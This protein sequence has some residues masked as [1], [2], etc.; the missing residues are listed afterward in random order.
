[1]RFLLRLILLGVVYVILCVSPTHGQDFW[2]AHEFYND[3]FSTFMTVEY[4]EDETRN[5]MFTQEDT[6]DSPYRYPRPGDP[7]LG[8]EC[9][10]DAGTVENCLGPVVSL[11]GQ[12]FTNIT[13]N[14]FPDPTLI[15]DI[16]IVDCPNFAKTSENVFQGMV[17]LE[18][19]LIQDTLL[20]IIPDLSDT[21]L[22]KLNLNHN[23][24]H[25]DTRNYTR[26]MM[27]ST[28]THISLTNNEII[29]LPSDFLAGTSV[30][31]A[32]F[33]NNKLKQFPQEAVRGLT[34]LV[35]L[36]VE[37]NEITSISKRNM[38]ALD[39][40]PMFQHLNL[41]NNLIRTIAAGAFNVLPN[42]QLLE[43]HQ[44]SLETLAWKVFYDLPELLYLDLNNNNLETLPANSLVNLPK[45]RELRL[46]SQKTPMT[47]I[48]F[49]AFNGI[50]SN[51]FMLWVSDNSLPNYPHQAL[52]EDIY[53][54][55][56][57]VH[58]EDNQIVNHTD[59][60]Q[61]AFSINLRA[62]WKA[63]LKTFVPFETT[64]N[65]QTLWLSSNRIEEIEEDDFCEM[66]ILTRLHLAGNLLTEDT[67][68]VTA[69]ACNLRLEFLDLSFNRIQYIPEAIRHSTGLPAIEELRLQSN[70]LTFL[71]RYA[72]SDLSTLK[73]LW[74]HN[75]GII[76]IEDGSFPEDNLNELSLYNNE[77]RF[78]HSN[79]F[80]NLGNLAE[81]L[82]SGNDIT[83]IPD[84]AFHGSPI[85]HLELQ[86]NKIGR[87]MKPHFRDCPMGTRLYLQNNDLAYI[88]DGSF[89]YFTSVLE[90]DLSNNKLT[91]L[92]VGGDFHDLN[93]DYLNIENN[94]I[95]RIKNGTFKNLATN[96]DIN[97]QTNR[98]SVIE[99]NAF[100]SVNSKK[101]TLQDNIIHHVYTES[102][103]DVNA[104][105]ILIDNSLLE[106]IPYCTFKN[107]VAKKLDLS[108]GKI[109]TIHD[110]AF[111]TVDVN[112]L[113]L[114][115]NLLSKIEGRLFSDAC[116]IGTLSLKSNLLKS[117][118]PETFLGLSVTTVLLEDN[119]IYVYP[120]QALSEINNIQQLS[121]ARN[122]LE[123]IPLFSFVTMINLRSLNIAENKLIEIKDDAFA[124]LSLL[125]DLILNNNQIQRIHDGAWNGLTNLKNLEI[126]N[127][128]VAY[129]PPFPEA[130][131]FESLDA[132]N[133]QIFAMADLLFNLTKSD[134]ISSVNLLNNPLGCSCNNYLS[135]LNVA[136]A[137]VGGECYFPLPR[138]VPALNYTFAKGSK[139][140]SHYFLNANVTTDDFQCPGYNVT[141]TALAEYELTVSWEQPADLI[142]PCYVNCPNGTNSSISPAML[143]YRVVCSSYVGPV[144]TFNLTSPTSVLIFSH[145]FGQAD[146]VV[147]GVDYS[148][149][150]QTDDAGYTSAKSAPSYITTI[151]VLSNLGG[152]NHPRD[153]ILEMFLT[154]FS[155]GHPDFTGLSEAVIDM[156]EYVDSPY[157]AWLSISNTPTADTFSDW[158]RDVSPSNHVYKEN[159]T[160][161]YVL[162][163]DPYKNRYF[164]FDFYPLDGRG[165]LAEGQ[166]DCSNI[167]HN[168]GF[169]SSIREGFIYQGDEVIVLAGGDE[170]W[171]YINKTLVL[172]LITDPNDV[173]IPCMSVDLTPAS[174]SGGGLIT[175]EIGLLSG[176]YDC[177]SLV[178]VTS[179][180]VWLELEVGE[181]FH[182]DMFHVERY[183][184]KSKIFIE[185]VG[186]VF[187]QNATEQPPLDYSMTVGEDFHINGIIGTVNLIDH[188]SFGPYTLDITR[189]NEGRHFTAVEDTPANQAL[190]VAPPV[191]PPTYTTLPGI[192]IS[193]VECSV[194]SVI[195]PDPDIPG[196]ESFSI[197]TST[198]LVT[199][200]TSLDYEYLDKYV[201][202]LKVTDQGTMLEGTICIRILLLDVN[203]NCPELS[204]TAFNIEAIPA[205]KPEP[206]LS[207]NVSDI[208]SGVNQDINF[209]ISDTISNPPLSGWND[210]FDLYE[211][212][213]NQTTDITVTIAAI[214]KG[215][216]P[217]GKT[218]TVTITLWNTCLID[219]LHRPV[220]HYPYVSNDTGEFYFSVPGY[221]VY[222][223]PCRDTIGIANAIIY[224]ELMDA[225]THH[226]LGYPGRGRLNMTFESY[227][228]LSGGWVADV[229]DTA[230]WIQADLMEPHII[231][232]IQL[233][234]REDE[235]EWV[236]QVRI[237][238]SNNTL[239]PFVT[240]TDDS[241]V[242]DFPG[243]S[244]RNTIVL[245]DLVPPLYGQIVRLNPRAWF[246]QIALRFEVV[247]C[248][249]QK[250]FYHDVN[251]Q[252]CVAGYY[253]EGD[254]LH[255]PCGWCDPD[256]NTTCNAIPSEHSYGE[257]SQCEP[258]PEGHIC[259][260]GL[261]EYCPE[262]HYIYC[263]NT[264][265]ATC[266]QC[267]T[268]Y[269]C[270]AGLKYACPNGTYSDGYQ[271]EC[272]MC[273]PGTYQ[274]LPL[275]DHCINCPTGFYS[276]AMKDQC[277]W[278]PEF[279]YSKPDGTGCVACD[280]SVCACMQDPYPCF[281]DDQSRVPCH[282][283]DG[284]GFT[285]DGC[286]GGYSGDGVTC[287]D[288]DE[289]FADKPCFWERCLNTVPGYQ[290]YECPEGYN[291]TYED[292]ITVIDTMRVF[293]YHNYE[294][295]GIQYQRCWDVDECLINN[296]RCDPH[297]T[298]FNAVGN[299]SCGPCHKGYLGNPYCTCYPDNFCETG[300]HTCDGNATCTYLG[301]AAYR[302]DCID[303]YSG[304]GYVC[305]IDF[306]L[307]GRPYR[308]IPCEDPECY[309]D[310][311]P[312]LP[313]SGQEDND[314][315]SAGDYCDDDDDNDG[316]PDW[317]D[318]C[319]LVFNLNQ[320]DTD[321]DGIGD[322]CDNC[323]SVNDT[324]Q[325]DTD[326]DGLGNPCDSDIDGDG[327]ANGADNCVYIAND[328]TNA[329][330]DLFGDA[331]DNCPI[332]SNNVQTD[333]NQN[334]YGDACDGTTNIDQDGDGVP[335][336]ADNCYFAVNP[337]QA[338]TDNDGI[339]D[340]CDDD[341]DGDGV[342]NEVDNCLYV[343]NSGQEDKN[344][345]GIGDVCTGDTDGDGVLDQY[346]AC[347]NN[348]YINTTDFFH[349]TYIDLDPTAVNSIDPRWEII[350]DG[351][352]IRQLEDAVEKP[353]ML[354]SK[355]SYETLDY[356][357][358]FYV[359]SDDK[360]NYIGFVFGYQN[361]QKFYV[362]M[363]QSNNTNKD[364]TA[365]RG[366]LRGLQIKVVTS[367][368]GPGKALGNALWHSADTPG[369]VK[370]IWHDPGMTG[371][372]H[373][374]PYRWHLYHRP[375]SGRIRFR[376]V[377]GN[378][379]VID[380]GNIY[381]TTIPGGRIGV[382]S[383]NQPQC[384]WSY[385]VAR[386]E[387]R[388]NE[389]LLLDGVDDYVELGTIAELGIVDSFTFETWL[390]LPDSY[391]S[392]KQPIICT[393]NS[394]LCVYIENGLLKGQ[395][396]TT[397]IE[398]ATTIQAEY[399]HHV[400]MRYDAQN[401]IL[402]LYINGT[403]L[404]APNP[405]A[406]Q[407]DISPVCW[408]IDELGL[409][410]HCDD[411]INND[412]TLYLGTENKTAFFQGK[413]D[414]VRL[415]N[416]YLQNTE[417]DGHMTSAGLWWQKH[418]QY[419]LVHL[420]MDE[421]D[422]DVI[423][424]DKGN[425]AHNCTMYGAPQ[426]VMSY[427]NRGRFENTY[428]NNRR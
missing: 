336:S 348:K 315:D 168:F 131:Q 270:N 234:G 229:S 256:S 33:A 368:T 179:Q 65:V 392:T 369:Q 111:C 400:T 403:S 286:P 180:S 135:L 120:A 14:T 22:T 121:L 262:F 388:I 275:Q 281:E 63:R 107:V 15:T 164:D 287:V 151:E 421:N 29:W 345:D 294:L 96:E 69:W 119:L 6:V 414:E 144:L 269:A 155:R 192:N 385:L 339:G 284:G 307:D 182:F 64:P 330:G 81:L 92:P 359:R 419:G 236:T 250:Q 292:G 198:S 380:S 297:S 195:T 80:S 337:S 9:D 326:L 254:G 329:D 362:V 397:I 167:V 4:T 58:A 227:K 21:I 79:P 374:T 248:P 70:K 110:Q 42:L 354:I 367:S 263:T 324:D 279:S 163:T 408:N 232:Q 382:F 208:D 389:A 310:N 190:G 166:R 316:K 128:Q 197:S 417:L 211:V 268:G 255:H 239:G 187:V 346:D 171:L 418:K 311:C 249:I 360:D 420:D 34:D 427:K 20:E 189:G 98:I 335:D 321:G 375:T 349:S 394:V 40:S 154:D 87:I 298:C 357:G 122:Q 260:Q 378:A 416:I 153:Y 386:C 295:D 290:C 126:Q 108:S 282:D 217:R 305:D 241:A 224:D 407:H 73:T 74:L 88:E 202:V 13:N 356:S 399:W 86:Y 117:I 141:T 16:T 213:Y 104:D 204:Q 27:P 228:L 327:T 205:L 188:F 291:G 66:T 91:S 51:L 395:Y 45:L 325:T 35:Y 207:I 59:Y 404:S 36:G 341:M 313:N 216:P 244:D 221:W 257:S 412:T 230:Q 390:M 105:N 162:G 106:E 134:S 186:M 317:A 55:L 387:D 138:I 83:V 25:F 320:A 57:Q 223:Y 253:C 140:E 133:N 422:D 8:C 185:T 169:T 17:Q 148:C 19:M 353:V 199:L 196:I 39:T 123:E 11:V 78:L 296:G 406:V 116:I 379:T 137:I 3:R 206:W 184:C 351:K 38:I 371:W 118:P 304:N 93:L 402:S 246:G 50:N 85:Q 384:V 361:N 352:E 178:P 89:D 355:A 220:P 242:T 347:R 170:M 308:N 82:L 125:T 94:R 1:M 156:P 77:F 411:V 10:I 391:S 426:F 47:S 172:Q 322:A 146:G 37:G 377:E 383:Y 95:T 183:W 423:L 174:N 274:D 222:N 398:G 261:A 18:T 331:C 53:P 114:N 259:H 372:V 90:M 68:H 31:F 41:S 113:L 158:F 425:A 12:T 413:V 245:I 150:V 240:Y 299:F 28:L 147:A 342:S 160:L 60:G 344:D 54:T 44:N 365:Y 214:D 364:L 235:N 301:P 43:L 340:A 366:G 71:Q 238:Y 252:R 247:G 401:Y 332:V 358:T 145:T 266:T 32:S 48:A 314:S 109:T 101:I 103:I 323:P 405:E 293:Q 175:P 225:S 30:K 243:S 130:T 46:H 396:G 115:N 165:F 143:D 276:S 2:P 193:F 363:W 61:E 129:L 218:A 84:D 173:N 288:V 237:L 231:H 102:F 149:T 265:P 409:W 67:I 283:L 333:T 309:R 210:T 258:C 271:T 112:N 312:N 24:I 300:Q 132:S 100:N 273:E 373:R 264:C 410:K 203:D 393:D 52:G 157:G 343:P 72:F 200:A 370:V 26:F 127:N 415:S 176:S 376:L 277:S 306:D 303:G 289:C 49:N 226:F 159:L 191:V 338:D 381:D 139:D 124:P 76:S 194:P 23:K 233:Q 251:C 177:L 209:Y 5:G 161:A 215:D 350:H 328:Q 212:V 272:L 285:C 278:C 152:G 280:P 56:A 334:G 302:C 424:Q 7:C 62:T 219:V 181:T 99:P 318:N 267:E 136:E 319:P 142:L 97:L 201:L 428:T 75:N